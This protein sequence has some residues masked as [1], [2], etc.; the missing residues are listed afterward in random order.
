MQSKEKSKKQTVIDTITAH[1]QTGILKP[2]DRMLGMRELA[3]KFN[4][5]YAVINDAYNV[6][7]A[8]KIIIRHLGS[9]TFINPAY[10]FRKT[11]MVALLT[12]YKRFSIEDY[13]DSL[14]ET[15]NRL[16]VLP[17]ISYLSPAKK[18]EERKKDICKVLNRNP[19]LILIDLEAIHFPL[20]EL[21]QIL[22][23]RRYC[24]THRWEWNE[25]VNGTAV[26]HDYVAAYTEALIHLKA[27]GNR[28]IIIYSFHKIP[29]PFMKERL[30]AA[31]EKAGLQFGKEL[32]LLP[33]DFVREEPRALKC[34]W[35]KE[36]PTAV[37][38]LSDYLMIDFISKA[39]QTCP[40][41]LQIDKAGIFHSHYSS[42]PGHE[43]P[44]I[45]LD[46]PKLWETALN[47]SLRDEIF[48]IQPQ[49]I[50]T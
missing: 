43:F 11:R 49:K 2:G 13:Y 32:F 33:R 50:C 44:S 5:S 37:F 47:Q 4:V 46:F 7:A 14:L 24:F 28:K 29:L 40:E 21:R 48:F 27:R 39:T 20:Q 34:L 9:G 10:K 30:T 38:A 8:E 31:A 18:L 25:P 16:D 22:Q 3:Q 15:A 42:Y 35:E 23:G 17:V 1:I 36:K 6:L 12:D 19:D 41:L 45:P 26:L